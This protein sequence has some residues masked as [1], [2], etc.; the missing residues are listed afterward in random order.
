MTSGLRD[1]GE[2]LQADAVGVMADTG[3]GAYEGVFMEAMARLLKSDADMYDALSQLDGASFSSAVLDGNDA[4]EQLRSALPDQLRRQLPNPIASADL[5]STH[6]PVARA[7]MAT[8]QK[9]PVGDRFG[10][11]MTGLLEDSLDRFGG[12]EELTREVTGPAIGSLPGESP[13]SGF[14]VRLS[15]F[16][17]LLAP[18]ARLDADGTSAVRMVLDASRDENDATPDFAGLM[19]RIPGLE[20]LTSQETGALVERLLTSSASDNKS[21]I[22]QITGGDGLGSLTG[23]GLLGGSGGL[24]GGGSGGSLGGGGTGDSTGGGLLGGGG[25]IS[26][27]G[28]LGGLLDVVNQLIQSILDLLN[29]LLGDGISGG[30]LGGG[31]GSG[32]SL[33]GEG[34]TGGGSGLLGGRSGSGG[35]LSGLVGGKGL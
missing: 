5:E 27:N 18:L 1:I 32:G 31:G 35:L 8:L 28:V 22:Q 34:S 17:D 6:L 33:G 14:T 21:T 10:D 25:S 11:V 4:V 19:R 9:T 7:V 16:G 13:F 12:P 15:D 26:D 20:N 30:L 24:L 23:G 2:S 3:Q 29:G